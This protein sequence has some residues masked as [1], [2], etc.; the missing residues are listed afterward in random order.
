MSTPSVRP[1]LT[2]R[3]LVPE[4]QESPV[5]YI[6]PGVTEPRFHFRRNHFPYPSLSP[7]R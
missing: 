6:T 3:G 1:F 5:H 7:L 4:N 2:T